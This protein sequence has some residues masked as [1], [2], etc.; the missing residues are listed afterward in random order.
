MTKVFVLSCYEF[1]KL[2]ER[3]SLP[4][5]FLLLCALNIFNIARSNYIYNPDTE[6]GKM[7]IGRYQLYL[8]YKGEITQ[9]KIA[10]IQYGA[11]ISEQ[12]VQSGN[13]DKQYNPDKYYSGYAYG[14]AMLRIEMNIEL[15]RLLE[16][17]LQTDEISEKAAGLSD[18]YGMS[19]YYL[20]QNREIADVYQNRNLNSITNSEGLSKLFEYNFSDILI[21][22]LLIIGISHIFTVDKENETDVYLKSSRNG[23]CISGI[24]KLIAAAGF[25]I[26]ICAVFFIID[27]ATFLIMLRID[28]LEQPLYIL[29]DFS[30]TPLSVSLWQYIILYFAAKLIGMLC[31]AFSVALIA[32][33]AKKAIPTFGLSV[34]YVGALMFLKALLTNGTGE[35]IN[36]FN[37]VSVLLF[38]E[39]T[40][41][42]SVIN[43]FG[44][45]VSVPGLAL[46][47]VFYV[48]ALSAAA[49][50]CYHVCR[51]SGRLRLRV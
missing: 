38:P 11:R 26:I 20:K 49:V 28:G 29:S 19:D 50:I 34:L 10:E 12:M 7:E 17:S 18:E 36:L 22:I 39:L 46:C 37:P 8:N 48:M 1:K 27:L 32:V 16:Y 51:R 6:A 25:T 4:V 47:G 30:S 14:E 31:I 21:I 41:T 43:L 33:F 9:D 23:G 15:D 3:K 44:D 42:Y 40:K 2:F 13:Y 35:Y 45:P 24:A 5:I